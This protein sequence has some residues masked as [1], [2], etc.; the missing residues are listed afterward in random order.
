MATEL[1]V[2]TTT[3]SGVLETAPA[4][5]DATGNY[6]TNTGRETIRIINGGGSPITATI[7]TQGTF[8]VGSVAYPIDDL[9]VVVTNG[10]TKTCGPFDRALFNDASNRVQIT[11]SAVTSVTVKVLLLGAS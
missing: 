3:A 11:W 5:A 7:V 6:F 4:A 10:T 9:A 2:Q 8:N 1:T